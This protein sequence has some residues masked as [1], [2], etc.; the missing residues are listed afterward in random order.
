M[1]ELATFK[2]VFAR[3]L[4]STVIRPER[5]ISNRVDVDFDS[6]CDNETKRYVGEK[7]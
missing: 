1:F 3:L 2:L 5:L 7:C 4:K 6:D